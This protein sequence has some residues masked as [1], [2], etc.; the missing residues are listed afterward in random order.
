LTTIAPVAPL[1]PTPATHPAKRHRLRTLLIVL[2]LLLVAGA[3]AAVAGLYAW[4]AGY[5]GR[6]L[7]GIRAGTTDLSGM[8][9]DQATAAL[10]AAYPLGQGRL[11]L[12]TPDGD[13]IVP[14]SAAGRRLD[15]DPMVDAALASGRTGS[16]LERAQA[17]LRQALT[18]TTIQP[19]MLLDEAALEAAIRAAVAPLAQDPVDAA[20]AVAGSGPVTTPSKTGR[21][22]DPAPAVAAAIAALRPLDAPDE[23]VIPVD[24]TA[25]E[26]AVSDA[27]VGAAIT[28]ALAE[29]DR[30]ARDVV[31]S[32]R[33]KTWKIRAATV[34]TWI[35]FSA[36]G[37][38]VQ[39]VI[40]STKIPASFKKARKAVKEKPQSAVFLKTRSGKVFGVAP[41]S[42]GRKL[43]VTVTADLVRAELETRALGT[44]PSRVKVA[45]VD[46]EPDVTTEEA[47][48]KAPVMTKLG[49]WTTW[50]PISDH[51]FY[52]A[53]IWMPAR[54]INGTVLRP[55]QTFDW[56]TAI[57]PVTS[58]RG[59]GA[60]AIIRGTYSDPTGAMGGGMCSSSTTLFNA[61]LRAG[62]RMGA[63]DNH[64][65]YIPRY[66][67]GLDATVWIMGG[68]TQSMTFTNDTRYPILI[69]GIKTSSGGT[70]YVTYELWGKPDGRTVTL[71]RPAVSNVVKATTE[72]EYV[73]TLPKGQRLQ[74]EYPSNQMDVSVTRVVRN[75]GGSVIHQEVWRTHYVLWNGLI[76]VGQ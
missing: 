25:V 36:S 60:G 58:A 29:A 11:V 59:F 42:N 69:R 27:A 50:F 24:T 73:S 16:V 20:V 65:Y 2:A 52:G 33:K 28:E 67:L 45:L 30:M 49:T 62:L 61:A 75:A 34:R 5:E 63:R 7:P 39:P 12:H 32:Y 66:P 1:D 40:D 47:G 74:L 26:P 55:G 53:N 14:Y 37:A 68:V 35:S 10:N 64:K 8:D 13:L 72:T 56:F 43:D 48:A 4:D 23:V 51:N 21:A 76:Q 38:T 57:G 41:G 15:A 44:V 19:A 46:L 22:V 54:Y 70:G 71:S 17:E 6:I 9:R 18:G 3:A 31:L